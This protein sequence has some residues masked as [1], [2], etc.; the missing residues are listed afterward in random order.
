MLTPMQIL[1]NACEAAN[2]TMQSPPQPYGATVVEL[3]KSDTDAAYALRSPDRT[4]EVVARL[5]EAAHANQQ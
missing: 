2:D 3:F 4:L 5:L 1:E